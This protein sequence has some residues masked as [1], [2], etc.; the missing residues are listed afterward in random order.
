GPARGG[1]AD[2][3]GGASVAGGRASERVGGATWFYRIKDPDEQVQVA[4]DLVRNLALWHGLDPAIL[5]I[6][7]LGPVKTVRQHALDR[8]EGIRW[9]GTAP[10]GSMDPVL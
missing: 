8:I 9:R 1:C 2:D 7:A 4:Q 10:D 6:D 5:R 3:L